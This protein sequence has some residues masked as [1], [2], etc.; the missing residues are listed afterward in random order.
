MKRCQIVV[1]EVTLPD[2]CFGLDVKYVNKVTMT[3]RSKMVLKVRAKFDLG[4]FTSIVDVY[5]LEVFDH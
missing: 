4:D 3:H 2:S 5:F 1:L